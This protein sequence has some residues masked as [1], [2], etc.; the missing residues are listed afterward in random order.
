MPTPKPTLATVARAVGV[1][2]SAVSRALRNHPSIP[3]TTR[4]RIRTCAEQLGYRPNPLVAALMA[5]MRESRPTPV[6]FTLGLITAFD[7][8]RP[9][10]SGRI[11]QELYDGM[12]SR[13][14]ERGYRLEEF[15]SRQKGLTARRLSQILY[16]RQVPGVIVCSL[17]T[18][19]GH[20]SLDWKHFAA[21]T[22]GYSLARPVLNRV[23]SHH[24]HALQIGMRELQRLGYR[25]I[26]L[27]V[28]AVENARVDGQWLSAYLGAQYALPGAEQ[29][30]PFLPLPRNWNQGAFQRWF[31]RNRPDALLCVHPEEVAP[32][33]DA[34]GLRIPEDLGI[35]D[36]Y[37]RSTF[38]DRFAA[39]SHNAFHIGT[40]LVDLLVEAIHLNAR[41]LPNVP[42]TVLVEPEWKDG[43][44]VRA[45][46]RAPAAARTPVQSA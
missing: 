16:Q 10:Q 12:V 24:V 43:A 36:L 5:G 29:L 46:K 23:I 33:I 37:H 6:E 45:R 27:V 14:E 11:V 41:G 39:V 15:W 42:K 44:S 34:L 9:W 18:A 1:S 22:I 35:V 3:P 30:P 2:I 32:W 38:A 17:P 25:R 7:Q 28:E 13:A 4:D 20:M 40:N 31:T 26:G 19:H 21:V 8:P